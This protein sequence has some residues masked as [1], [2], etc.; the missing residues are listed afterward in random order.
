MGSEMYLCL[1]DAD[2]GVHITE[3]METCRLV[4]DFFTATNNNTSRSRV[5]RPT[6]R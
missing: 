1:G 5:L 4:D 2:S 3:R 6:F